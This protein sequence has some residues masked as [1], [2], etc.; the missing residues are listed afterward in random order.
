VPHKVEREKGDR[1][2]TL[3]EE[4]TSRANVKF[5]PPRG[6][7]R[8]GVLCVFCAPE[9]PPCP[10][11]CI[12]SQSHAHLHLPAHFSEMRSC[13]SVPRD[14]H[15]LSIF[16]H[17]AMRI[18]AVRLALSPTQVALILISPNVRRLPPLPHPRSLN[19]GKSNACPLPPAP[20]PSIS[21][22]LERALT[23]LS[24][25]HPRLPLSS[26]SMCDSQQQEAC[27]GRGPATQMSDAGGR[28]CAPRS[29]HAGRALYF[30]PRES[31]LRDGRPR[32]RSRRPARRARQRQTWDTLG[33][34]S[35]A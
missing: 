4:S 25:S 13:G 8:A 29:S 26:I 11:P 27:T 2:H 18:Y 3:K 23:H 7:D 10:R 22:S 14:D 5:T 32:R 20:A 12:A 9:S 19:P 28:A 24:Y 6:L 1:N 21:L 34:R 16:S 30:L 17:R 15:R 31:Q 35:R 33:G